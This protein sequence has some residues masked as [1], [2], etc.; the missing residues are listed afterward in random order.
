M[1]TTNPLTFMYYIRLADGVEKLH[2]S[3]TTDTVT[4]SSW[5]DLVDKI[6]EIVHARLGLDGTLTI[7]MVPTGQVFEA[8]MYDRIP[9]RATLSVLI[10]NVQGASMGREAEASDHRAL[11][12]TLESMHSR[13]ARLES[14]R[15]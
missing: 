9:P 13:L 11:L 1:P 12:A 3:G 4:H 8:R 5:Q 14:L 15:I 7:R 6:R 10:N 2:R